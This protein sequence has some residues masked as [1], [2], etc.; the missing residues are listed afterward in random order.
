MTAGVLDGVRVLD[1]GRYVAGPYC[2]TLL[3]Y[4][5]ADVI[6]I[7]RPGG[8]EDR[9]IAPVSTGGDGAVFLQ[10][11]CNKRSL[12]LKP[13]TPR[14]REIVRRLVATADVVVANLPDATLRRLGLDYASLSAIKP[15]IVLA[16]QS[17]FGRTGPW[18]ARGGFDGVGQAMSGAMF[19]TGTPGNPV[20]AAAPYVDYATAVLSA[21]GVLAALMQR[22]QSGKGQEIE[23]TL[24]GTALA[25]FNAHLIEQGVLGLNRVGTGNRVQTSAPSD[26]FATRDGHV[27]VHVPSDHLFARWARL[28]GEA[29]WLAD[30]RFATDA[31]RGA[32]RDI[33]CER[34]AAWCR[35]RTS[36][37]VLQHLSEAGIPAAP[38]LSLQQAL[39]H[40][41]TA[42]LDVLRR[43]DYP[44]LPQ[45]APIADLPLRMQAGAVGVRMPPPLPG[46]HNRTILAELGYDEAEIEALRCEGII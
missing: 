42:A 4:L 27:L 11:A 32:H 16:S 3:G 25:V 24:L 19:M 14:G 10:T 39:E 9:A 18:A 33:I 15:D 29:H 43:V 37:D 7:E 34:M 1:F 28:M 23:G 26:V 12:T 35:V 20:K 8:G 46:Q 31:L 41:Q 36:E 21:F 2:A 45:A 17:A 40:P 5:G 13:A 38:V 44:G 30:P 22:A 6:R